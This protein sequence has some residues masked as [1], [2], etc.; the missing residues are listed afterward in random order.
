LQAE[1]KQN[2]RRQPHRDVGATPAEKRLDAI[3][4]GWQIVKDH[5]LA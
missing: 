4:T 2:E 5:L 1:A 3:R